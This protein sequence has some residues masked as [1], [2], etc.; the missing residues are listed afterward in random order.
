[1]YNQPVQGPATPF[2]VN[3]IFFAKPRRAARPQHN[4]GEARGILAELAKYRC[5]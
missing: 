3:H 4:A 5:H 2:V 1:M